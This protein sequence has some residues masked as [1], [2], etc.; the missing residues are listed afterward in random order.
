MISAVMNDQPLRS[1]YYL[2]LACYYLLF[3]PGIQ[4][5]KCLALI[6]SG[7]ARA[8]GSQTANTPPLATSL[9]GRADEIP[10]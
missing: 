8:R 2:F 7:L 4:N 9:L 10:E 1:C 3:E 5:L 6:P